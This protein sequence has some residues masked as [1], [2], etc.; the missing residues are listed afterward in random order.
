MDYNKG[1]RIDNCNAIINIRDL[2]KMD[3]KLILTVAI[4][5]YNGSKTIRNM[6]DILLP[7][8]TENVE[9]LISDNCSTDSTPKIVREYQVKYPFI[10]YWRNEE[11]IGTD[12]NIIK[13]FERAV[14]EFVWLLSDDDIAIEGSVSEIISFVNQHKELGLIYLTTV[15]FRGKYAGVQHCQIRKPVAEKN[16]CTTNKKDFMHYAGKDWGFMSSFICSKAR[17]D[18]IKNPSQYTGTLWLQSY[19]HTLCAIGNVTLLGVISKPCV[20]AGIYINTANFDSA[21]VNGVAYKKLLDFMSEKAGFDKKQLEDLYCWRMCLLGRHDIVKEKASGKHKLNKKLL[22]QCM[23]KY[24]KAWLTLFPFY[25][26][27]DGICKKGMEAYRKR[28]GIKGQITI[29][30]PNDSGNEKYGG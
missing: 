5:T 19:I 28:K 26:V 17:Y 15:H 13:C 6:F 16:I 18:Q 25:L 29:N 22:F 27:P 14:G 24:P 1:I 9:V 2:I 10:S 21:Q 12:G 11:N 7:Q 23:W 20:G 4:P 8:C 3:D 30:R